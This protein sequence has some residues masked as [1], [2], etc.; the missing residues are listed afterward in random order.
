MSTWRW[1]TTVYPARP[2]WRH[3]ALSPETV[4]GDYA[5]HIWASGKGHAE[6]LA[7][8]RNIGERVTGGNWRKRPH[9]LPSQL[10]RGNRLT[11][12]RA[13]DAIHSLCFMGYLLMRATGAK[14]ED[15]LGDEG[16]LHMG[17]HALSF[18]WPGRR[19]LADALEYFENR[20]P[21]FTSGLQRSTRRRGKS[22][23]PPKRR[24][25]VAKKA[26]SKGKFT[27]TAKGI[28]KGTKKAPPMAP[29]PAAGKPY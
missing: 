5:S 29:K 2:A 17:I 28:G 11:K 23:R 22:A 20:I 8:R 10:L 15:V 4:V 9:Q 26:G 27:K 18:G 12:R 21:G 24:L 19:R 16:L 13:L 7:R 25:I 1:W 14:A 6:K 3:E